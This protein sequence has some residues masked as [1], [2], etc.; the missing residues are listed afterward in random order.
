VRSPTEPLIVALLD[1]FQAYRLS[2]NWSAM[3]RLLHPQARLESLAA[4]GA[5][6]SPQQLVAAIE[7]AMTRGLYSVRNWAVELLDPH[8]AMADGRVRYWVGKAAITDEARVWVSSDSPVGDFYCRR[9]PLFVDAP[10]TSFA[11]LAVFVVLVFSG[12]ADLSP[13]VT[14]TAISAAAA[15]NATSASVPLLI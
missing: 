3:L 4:P 2:R 6:L 7:T 10:A 12:C 1:D 5:V 13:A 11:F 15:T 8:T 9:V 14:R